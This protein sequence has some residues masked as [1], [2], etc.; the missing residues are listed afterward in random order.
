MSVGTTTYLNHL[1]SVVFYIVRMEK[2]WPGRVV[3]LGRCSQAEFLQLADLRRCPDAE[4]YIANPT[5]G[6]NDATIEIVKIVPCVTMEDEQNIL[7]WHDYLFGQYQPLWQRWIPKPDRKHGRATR[8]V[9][10]IETGQIYESAQ[11]VARDYEVAPSR[12][13]GHLRRMAGYA[14]IKGHTFQYV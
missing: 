8:E 2:Y 9:Q 1:K 10:C 13:S 14:K 12:V 3:Y 5:T 4:S 6:L 11:S 7:K